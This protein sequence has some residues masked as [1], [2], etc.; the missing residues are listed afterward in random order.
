MKEA[1]LI[2]IIDDLK[3]ELV[4]IKDK[5]IKIDDRHYKNDLK[6]RCKRI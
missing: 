1:D 2:K 4:L 6:D 5:L 3:R